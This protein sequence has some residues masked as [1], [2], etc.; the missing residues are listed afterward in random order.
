MIPLKHT[1]RFMLVGLVR[2][3]EDKERMIANFEELGSL[4]TTFGGQ[5]FAVATQ[6][7]SR[8]DYGTYIGKGKTFEVAEAI[9]KE[10][11]DIVVINDYVK[12][13]Q[14]HALKNIFNEVNPNIIVWDRVDLILQIFSKHATTAESKLQIRLASMRHMGPRIYGM[15]QVL[16]Q[17]GGGIGT[18]GIGE[19]NTELM[20]RH[21]RNEMRTVREQIKKLLQSRE[22]QMDRRKRNGLPTISIVGYTNAGK[23]SLFNILGAKHNLAEDTL[24]ATLDSSVCTLYLPKIKKEVF[25]SD[26]IGFIQNLP[27]PLI[28]S[29]KSTLMETIHAD[30]LLQVIDIS[31]PWMHDKIAVVE[32]ILHDLAIDTKN[33]I[34]VFNKIDK[35][36]I[37]KEELFTR[38]SSFNPQFIST[39]T[40]K[41]I[42]ELLTTIQQAL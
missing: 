25:V 17:Q 16:S 40:H 30:L 33:Q 6:N 21:W 36:E 7:S 3:Q 9:K 1:L 37:N 12:S 19:T 39:K 34:Y 29:F 32:K 38:Y 5:V 11:I 22:Q 2:P 20:K 27:T 15:G 41:G 14:L 35:E 18:R 10:A 31:D 13:G 26:T 42:D 4:V 28:D 24:F 8:A 23:T